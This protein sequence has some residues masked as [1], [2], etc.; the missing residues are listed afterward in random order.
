M[1]RWGGEG[2]VY[3]SGAGEA[4]GRGGGRGAADGLQGG[5]PGRLVGVV[6]LR[7]QPVAAAVLL[8]GVRVL[9][10][11]ELSMVHCRGERERERQ[12]GEALEK[13]AVREV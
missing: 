12:W 3:L 10:L 9:L 7:G 2:S 8:E 6:L 13:A 1:V 5:G 4:G 11:G